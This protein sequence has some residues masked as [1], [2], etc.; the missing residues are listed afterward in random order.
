[1]LFLGGGSWLLAAQ[2]PDVAQQLPPNA[3]SLLVTLTTPPN[4][5]TVSRFQATTITAQAVGDKP[6]VALE[7]WVDGAPVETKNAP[8]GSALRL[9]G[10]WNWTP[11]SEGTHVLFVRA[12]DAD[13]RVS[14]SNLARVTA[15]PQVVYLQ[16]VE[17]TPKSGETVETL[18]RKFK[19]TPQD[20][21]ALNSQIDPR[22]SLPPSQSLFI[23]LPPPPASGSLVPPAGANVPPLPPTGTVQPARSSPLSKIYFWFSKLGLLA[24]ATLPNPPEL[25]ASVSACD[26]NLFLSD[27]ADNEIG[28]FVHR[29][30]PGAGD[31]KRIAILDASSGQLPIQYTDRNLFGKFAYYI[32]SFNAKGESL[33]NV[34]SVDIGDANC[35]TPQWA[36]VELSQARLVVSQPV[37]RMY[38][39]LRINDEPWQR[40]P[41]QPNTFI[42]PGK[43]G[44]DVRPYLH[45]LPPGDVTVDAEWWGWQGNTLRYLGKTSGT[46][47]S[48]QPVSVELADSNTKTRWVVNGIP[49]KPA[50]VAVSPSP[51]PQPQPKPKQEAS[52]SLRV[53]TFNTYLLSP[54]MK[55]LPSTWSPL[56]T[57]N[58]PI[59]GLAECLITVDTESAA[60][61]IAQVL[62]KNQT[63]Y[64]I[65]AL[66]EVWD[67]DAKDILKNALDDSF[68]FY[69]KY[70]NPDAGFDVNEE[71][72][73]LMFFSKFPF[74]DMPKNPNPVLVSGNVECSVPCDVRS[75]YFG[76]ECKGAD[77]LANKGAGLV[78]VQQSS[79]RIVNIVFSH[80]QAYYDFETENSGVREKQLA[81]IDQ[82]VGQSLS[83]PSW[84]SSW[85]NT[86]W[87][88]LMGDLNVNGFGRVGNALYKAQN[89]N[90]GPVKKQE[91]WEKFGQPAVGKKQTPLFDAWGETT[92][93][94]D[95]GATYIPSDNTE[96]LDYILASRDLLDNRNDI[97]VQHIW[98]P[99]EFIG[100]SDHKAVAAD[101]NRMADYC[102]PRIA[103]V[104]DEEK[105]EDGWGDKKTPP[106]PGEIKFPGSM[107]WFYLDKPG[108]YAIYADQTVQYELYTKDNLSVPLG[109]DLKLEKTKIK[110][111]PAADAPES[112]CSEKDA[113][114]WKL[115]EPGYVRV[116]GTT[117]DWQGA[118]QVAIYRY[119]CDKPEEAC[120][121]VP[122]WSEKFD[123]PDGKLLNQ[124]D[125]AFFRIQVKYQADSGQAQQLYFSAQFVNQEST[126]KEIR[127]RDKK[128]NKLT[129]LKGKNKTYPLVYDDDKLLP[130]ITGQT[131]ENHALDNGQEVYLWVK[132]DNFQAAQNKPKPITVKVFWGT[133][134]TILGGSALGDFARLVCTDETNGAL[135]S[136]AGHDEIRMR[137]SVDGGSE[138]VLP[139]PDYV[140]FDC[141]DWSDVVS[142]NPWE[143]KRIPH[144][145]GDGTI[146]FLHSVKIR[147]EEV[148][149]ASSSDYS[150][151]YP[152]SAWV[153]K[154]DLSADPSVPKSGLVPLAIPFKW[155]GGS[156]TF[157]INMSKRK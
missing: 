141:N 81:R 86:E 83:N 56:M 6:I 28:F 10:V 144:L 136:E 80:L 33:S 153:Q 87:L 127:L 77:C 53:L 40:V 121:L 151:E 137:L 74:V 19:T 120:E 15:S 38:F 104:V 82:L 75:V 90:V 42:R 131:D 84:K 108:T 107:Q 129:N 44:F 1:L 109:G 156:Y 98:I 115:I 122:N 138:G 65:I 55:C 145:G 29:L 142:G 51:T 71:D 49:A 93:E 132:R 24:P 146:K 125:A 89:P 2:I 148:D 39:Y 150:D 110:I 96:R 58:M 3:A 112:R 79:G 69:V 73:G 155:E 36:S 143:V 149:D 94:V 59:G 37:D 91:W 7:L 64:D 23:T 113:Q 14:Q 92:S 17:Y 30:D 133:N 134:L 72:S 70:L 117:R 85:N 32:S 27:K 123:F 103:R 139:H 60:G 102:N 34:Y 62:A 13:Q 114:K 100:L 22:Q 12:T 16:T 48:D 45:R 52:D 101:L 18:A 76:D 97:C 111:C 47:K 31:F 152:I 95:W 99:Q 147:F 43:G 116:F 130:E 8:S 68:P 119:H 41:W 106:L 4:G 9:S 140:S 124:D 126:I 21:I 54:L 88:L 157:Y 5:S 61:K 25:V 105:N 46:I 50:T 26:V 135:D 66:N 118:Y 57:P 128:G 67:E 78:R 35:F 11:A 154:N 20:I 63:K